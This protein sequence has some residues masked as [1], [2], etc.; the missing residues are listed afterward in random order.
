[1]LTR[2]K[3]FGSSRGHLQLEHRTAYLCVCKR[4]LLRCN[5]TATFSFWIELWPMNVRTIGRR[6]FSNNV[7]LDPQRSPGFE[8]L[9]TVRIFRAEVLA[10]LVR[11]DILL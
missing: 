7:R 11:G 4:C 1:M 10:Q 8:G 3:R 6:V 9:Q 5:A 2:F